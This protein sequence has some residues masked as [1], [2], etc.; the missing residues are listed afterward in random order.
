MND[1]VCRF[2]L[3]IVTEV[4]KIIIAA[5][6][7]AVLS[8]K[9]LQIM[10]SEWSLPLSLATVAPPAALYAAQN[11]L[12]QASYQHQISS[13]MFNLLNQTKTLSAAF[14]IYVVMG[15]GQSKMQIFAL[16]LLLASAV[17]LNLDAFTASDLLSSSLSSLSSSSSSSSASWISTLLASSQT[18]NI[19]IVCVLLASM[20]SGLSA[21]L[22]QKVLTQSKNTNSLLISAQ[23]AA[24]GIVFLVAKE[25]LTVCSQQSHQDLSLS[26]STATLL[27]AKDFW[28]G[29]DCWVRT[30]RAE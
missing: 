12:I 17:V 29:W 24:Y 1:G 26:L 14:W 20:I 18:E 2:S 11:T 30:S 15:K 23:L 3:I 9:D 5:A 7:F 6:S 28:R 8:R 10:W 22:T 4:C 21:A 25:L 19:A 13:M 27:L 16:V